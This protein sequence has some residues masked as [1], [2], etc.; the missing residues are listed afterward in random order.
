M[1]T[2]PNKLTLFVAKRAELVL[3]AG[4]II[5]DRALAEDVVQEAYLRFDAAHD[6]RGID[7]PLAYLYGIVRNLAL[8]TRRRVMR[9]QNRQIADPAIAFDKLAEDEPTP[10]ASASARQDLRLLGE[11]MAELPEN[12]RIA[13]EMHRFGNCTFKQIAEHLGISVGQA[14]SLVIRALE[15]CRDK[16]YRKSGR[17]S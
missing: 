13:M 12:M 15:I 10:E 6:G 16:L 11:A 3:Y 9:D 14:H 8:D 2:E 7:E 4:R 5:G 1:A 17:K